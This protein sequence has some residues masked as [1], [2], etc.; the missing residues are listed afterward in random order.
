MTLRRRG[1]F[2]HAYIQ[3][4][5]MNRPQLSPASYPFRHEPAV[6]YWRKSCD[7]MCALGST[8]PARNRRACRHTR[9]MDGIAPA[10]AGSFIRFL[11]GGNGSDEVE[12]EMRA[13]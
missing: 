11:L 5:T 3:Q 10:V 4:Q 9:Q 2:R 8:V 13:D 12:F 6:E 1:S 7:I